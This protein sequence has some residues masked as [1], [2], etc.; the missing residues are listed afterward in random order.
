MTQAIEPCGK[1]N[2][3][4]DVISILKALLLVIFP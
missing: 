4:L 1:K 2:L 3:M